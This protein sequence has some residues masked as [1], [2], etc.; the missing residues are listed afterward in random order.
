MK[1]FLGWSNTK[2]FETAQA[3]NEWLPKVIQ[4]VDPFISSGI[5]KGKRWGKVLIDELE[6]T[7]VGILCLTRENLDSN[8]LLYEAGALSKTKDA[9]VCTFLLDLKPTDIEE[10]LASFQHTI[11]EKDDIRKLIDTINK[12]VENSGERSLSENHLNIIFETFWPELKEELK[13]IVEKEAEVDQPIRE[14][15]EILEEILAIV[16]AQERRQRQEER[17]II[18]PFGEEM[19]IH[20]HPAYETRVWTT[21]VERRSEVVSKTPIKTRRGEGPKKPPAT[22]EDDTDNNEDSEG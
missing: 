10:P 9:Y 15:R 3:F 17:Q 13:N 6:E 8:W 11:F 22:E 16:R 19:G 12:A 1:V 14:E 21:P 5:P 7:K 4:A 2:S 20:E 18:I